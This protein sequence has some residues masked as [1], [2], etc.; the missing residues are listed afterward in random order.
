MK[1]KE[2]IVEKAKGQYLFTN[3]KKYL[4]FSLSSGTMILGH[5]NNI[6]KKH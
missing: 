4:D 2:I 3:N 6:F 1:Q 5:S